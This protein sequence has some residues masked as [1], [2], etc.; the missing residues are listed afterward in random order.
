MIL[1]LLAL[2]IS[3]TSIGFVHEDEHGR[4]TTGTIATKG[5]FHS[6]IFIMPRLLVRNLADLSYTMILIEGPAKGYY[7]REKKV[8]SEGKRV[9]PGL[10]SLIQQQRMVGAVLSQFDAAYVE[11]PPKSGKKA[12]TGDGN[13][14]KEH[15]LLYARAVLGDKISEHVADALGILYAGKGML[16]TEKGMA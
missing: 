4:F 9:G 11:V 13:A 14:S 10:D 1:T 3:S 6:R 15:M 2:D 7:M 16:V 5:T 12:L 8:N